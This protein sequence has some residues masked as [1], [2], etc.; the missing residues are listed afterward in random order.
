MVKA[1]GRVSEIAGLGLSGLD[2]SS[3]PARRVTE[4]GRYGMAA[5]APALRRHPHTR[6]VATLLATVRHLHATAIDDA[7]EVFDQLMTAELAGRAERASREERARSW[8]RLLKHAAKL[9]AAVKVLF[10]ARG[11][12]EEVSLPVVWDAIENI[13][14]AGE[15]HAAMEAVTELAP[16]VDADPD[17][18]WRARLVERYRTVRGFLPLL[19]QVI[20]FD[21][22]PAATPVLEAMRA[23]PD[24]VTA[25]STS[26]VPSGYLDARKANLEL[27]PPGWWQRLALPADRPAGTV[28]KAGYVFCLLEQ[29][30]RLCC[31]GISSPRPRPA[32]PIPAPA[33]WPGPPGSARRTP[34]STRSVCRRIRR[35]CWPGGPRCWTT[36]G[37]RSLPACSRAPRRGWMPRAACTPEPS[38]P[39]RIR[40]A[41]STCA[42]GWG[43]CCQGPTCRS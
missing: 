33:C 15:L 27:I 24:L 1:L 13:V 32:G 18:E 31:G 11:W 2:L 5:K 26:R 22:T 30:H 43:G 10:E 7:L 3:V 12:G 35:S 21:A 8:P 4:L 6:K 36:P 25:R 29:F 40:R 42:P 20:T 39:T 28:H 41:W 38:A 9:A 19:C 37:Q 17:G 34:S 16:P 14:P 23:L